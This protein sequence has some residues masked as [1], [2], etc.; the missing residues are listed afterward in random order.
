MISFVVGFLIMFGAVGGIEQN[1]ATLLEGT[2]WAVLGLS[3]MAWAVP[4]LQ[5]DFA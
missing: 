4:K 2:A 5:R 1:T 3:L